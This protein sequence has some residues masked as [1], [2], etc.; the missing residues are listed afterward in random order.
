MSSD[1]RIA[2]L[3]INTIIIA[4]ANFGSKAIT[5][6]LDGRGIWSDGFNNYNDK[7][8]CTYCLFRYI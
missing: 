7:P 2:E 3:K 6:I 8:Y 1:K 4:I 5:F